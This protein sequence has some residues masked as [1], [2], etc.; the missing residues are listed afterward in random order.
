[1]C[2]GTTVRQP[3]RALAVPRLWFGRG[4]ESLGLSLHDYHQTC[5]IKIR[6]TVQVVEYSTVCQD[7]VTG[8]SWSLEL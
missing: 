2:K 4:F 8:L 6:A 1:M 3:Q 5:I 7:E